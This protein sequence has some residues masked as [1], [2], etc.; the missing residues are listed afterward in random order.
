MLGH[1]SFCTHNYNSITTRK[2]QGKDIES[3][4]HEIID[5]YESTGIRIFSFNDSSLKTQGY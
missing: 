3:L 4:F 2:W 1:C 5:I